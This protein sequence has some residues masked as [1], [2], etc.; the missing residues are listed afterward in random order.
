MHHVT[1]GISS[2][3][4]FVNLILFTLLLVH[5][6]LCMSPYHSPHLHSNHI[7]LPLPFT[8][9]L[10]LN[11]LSDSSDIGRILDFRPD[12]VDNGICLL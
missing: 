4:Y 6:I 3:L 1:C 9:D 10:K 7:S 11:I 8:P 5:L 2:L 12:Y